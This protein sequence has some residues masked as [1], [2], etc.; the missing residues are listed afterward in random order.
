MVR[1]LSTLMQINRHLYSFIISID[2]STIQL[3]LYASSTFEASFDGKQE[4]LS[5]C[6]IVE[7][8][9]LQREKPGKT[10]KKTEK[11]RGLLATGLVQATQICSNKVKKT[12]RVT[13]NIFKNSSTSL[14]PKMPGNITSSSSLLTSHFAFSESAHFLPPSIDRC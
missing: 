14:L 10:K 1:S 2:T 13:R 7:G 8:K 6:I 12:I 4:E 3:N 5:F 11:H 9:T